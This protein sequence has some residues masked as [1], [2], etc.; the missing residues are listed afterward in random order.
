MTS[1]LGQALELL[2]VGML[3]VGIVLGLVVIT[4]KLLI[5][6]MNTLGTSASTPPPPFPPSTSNKNSPVDPAIIA[7][8]TAT[9]EAATQGKG[10]IKRIDP[11]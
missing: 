9:V 5:K 4:G 2:L 10:S 1:P 7:V 3:T 11:I 8:L 6:I